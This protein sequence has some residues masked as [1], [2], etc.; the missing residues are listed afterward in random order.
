MAPDNRF[1]SAVCPFNC[2]RLPLSKNKF[3]AAPRFADQPLC[4]NPALLFQFVKR[5]IQRA[6]SDLQDIFR[7]LFK[8]LRKRPPVHRLQSEYSQDER[9]VCVLVPRLNLG[10]RICSAI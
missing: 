3:D 4:G 9:A 10:S 5:G 7:H 6:R 2:L 1:Q 8:A